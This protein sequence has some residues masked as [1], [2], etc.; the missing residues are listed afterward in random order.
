MSF[1]GLVVFFCCLELIRI[2]RSKVSLL[3]RHIVAVS[4][5]CVWGEERVSKEFLILLFCGGARTESLG[6]RTAF[7]K[8]SQF[9]STKGYPGEDVC[10]PV[11]MDGP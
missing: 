4:M 2:V 8:K 5:T 3:M 7:C 11:S 6:G 1:E 10:E 9:D